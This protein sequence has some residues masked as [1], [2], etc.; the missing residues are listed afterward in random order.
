MLE[1]TDSLFLSRAQVA[2]LQR[3]DSAFSA[4]VRALYVP[5]GEFLAQGQ[6]GAGKA[7]LDSVQATQK[8][9]WKI[10]WEQPEIA[11]SIVTPSQKE[12]SPDAE[13]H[14]E[15]PKKDREHSQW[16]FGHPVAYSDRP[17][18][19]PAPPSGGGGTSVFV[20]RED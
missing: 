20:P 16:Q 5:L 7:E 3:A 8:A 12:L 4:Q 17:A 1:Q 10:F 18:P 13:R 9:Y 2:A 14:G 11:D 15:R 6:G 19:K